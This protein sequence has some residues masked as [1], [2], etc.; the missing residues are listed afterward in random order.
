LSR[1]SPLRLRDLGVEKSQ[2]PA[3]VPAS[4][5]N[6]MNGNPRSLSDSELSDILE[7]L[8]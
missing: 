1:R 5:G 6:S 7:A 2:L 8:W 4:R 3:L